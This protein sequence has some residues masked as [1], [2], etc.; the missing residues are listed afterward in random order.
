MSMTPLQS[1]AIHW[2]T[3]DIAGLYC[4]RFSSVCI[5]KAVVSR[6]P[7]LL[8]LVPESDC[9]CLWLR[10]LV[11]GTQQKWLKAVGL[12][13]LTLKLGIHTRGMWYMAY[14]HCILHQRIHTCEVRSDFQSF[15]CRPWSES[16][17]THCQSMLQCARLELNRMVWCL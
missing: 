15:C 13:D 3:Q 9:E 4:I 7:L 1:W 17:P 2:T 14:G 6:S 12:L 5:S 10:I 11:V 8:L 16:M